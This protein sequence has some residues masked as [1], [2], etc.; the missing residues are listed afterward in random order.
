MRRIVAGAMDATI[1]CRATWRASAAL[2]QWVTCR[3]QAIGSRQASSTI[4]ARWRGGNPGRAARPVGLVEQSRHPRVAVAP[5]GAAHR[6]D[7]AFQPGGDGR[8]PLARGDRQ[9]RAGAAD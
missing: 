6:A 3:P 8:G 4:W 9:D 7:V 2:L 5:A 1:P